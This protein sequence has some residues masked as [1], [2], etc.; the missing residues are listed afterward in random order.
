M[1]VVRARDVRERERH[2]QLRSQGHRLAVQPREL[3]G[4][5]RAR[6]NVRVR[7]RGRVRGRVGVRVWVTG[8]SRP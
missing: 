8:P 1:P 4:R 6:I 2:G 5:V 3:R 7:V